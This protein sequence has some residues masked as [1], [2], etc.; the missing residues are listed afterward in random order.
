M[1]EK[2]TEELRGMTM[3]VRRRNSQVT[4]PVPPGVTFFKLQMQA[5]YV[6]GQPVITLFAP[7]GSK[8]EHGVEITA[9]PLTAPVT[10]LTSR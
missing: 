3:N 7:D 6:N 2:T 4:M 8:I 9:D 10:G 1:P 5:K